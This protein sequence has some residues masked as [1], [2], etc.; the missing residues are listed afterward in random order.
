VSNYRPVSIL[1]SPSKVLEEAVRRQLSKYCEDNKIIP[2]SQ[3]GFRKKLSTISAVCAAHH[4]WRKA[5]EARLEVGALFF[6]LSAAFD[7][8]DSTILASKLELYGAGG[9]VTAWITSYLTERKQ[10]V[11]YGG[12][13]SNEEEVRVGSP[14]GS[15]ISP[16]LFLILTAD[17]PEWVKEAVLVTYA[18]DTTVYVWGETKAAVR[19]KLETAAQEI[20]S[21]MAAA[22]LAANAGKTKFIMFSRNKEAAPLTVGTAKIE[23]GQREPLLGF[24]ISK[25]TKWTQ[26]FEFVSHELRKRIG[27]LRRLRYHLPAN[28]LTQMLTAL[29]TSKMLYGIEVFTNSPAVVFEAGKDAILSGLQTLQNKA[30]RAVLGVRRG[31]RV[32]QRE[33]LHRTGQRSVL[34]ISLTAVA[35]QAWA[36]F[37]GGRPEFLS[38]RLQE[39]QMTSARITRAATREDIPTQGVQFSLLSNIVKVWNR[40]PV[41]IR[42]CD[43]VSSAKRKIRIYAQELCSK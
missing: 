11:L 7:L 29:F 15:I 12:S 13:L 28:I 35:R 18:D 34:Q 20:L 33:L 5:K 10:Q 42:K 36:C 21:F 41:D 8:I 3:H 9:N 25:D 27:L 38:G 24:V 19:A 4:D 2:P 6:D 16:L 43:N 30:M 14:Q 32:S 17:M 23:E 40:L 22:G 26:H 1:P 31:D 37:H 39:R